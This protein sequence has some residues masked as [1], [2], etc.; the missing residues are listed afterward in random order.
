MKQKKE[1]VSNITCDVV[2]VLRSDATDKYNRLDL[3]I[4]KWSGGKSRVLEKRRVWNLKDG[5]LRH[6]QLV[7]LSIADVKF[8]VE[9]Q[10]EIINILGEEHGRQDITDAI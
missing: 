7:G 2:K 6:R 9:H 5:T 10:E 3:R 4:V 8:I 1:I